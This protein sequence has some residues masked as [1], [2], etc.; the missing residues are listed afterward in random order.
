M[1]NFQRRLVLVHVVATLTIVG[2]AA[3]AGWWELSRSVYGQLDAALLALAETEAGM[4]AD[5]KGQPVH[6][7]EAP[8]GTAPPSLA[9]LDRLVQIVDAKGQVLARSANLGVARLPAAP[10][11]LAELA[12]GQTVFET[13]PHV[14]EEPLRMVSVP[15]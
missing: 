10:A 2:V 11:L 7:H 13:L 12:D 4:L 1:L 8:E 3:W 15:T 14:S 5:A 6:V 9:R